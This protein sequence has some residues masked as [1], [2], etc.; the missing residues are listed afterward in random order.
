MRG[1]SA[2]GLRQPTR[3][4]IAAVAVAGTAL[5]VAA[6][7]TVRAPGG[8]QKTVNGLSTT[9]STRTAPADSR[10]GAEAYAHRLLASLRLPPGAQELPWSAKLARGLSPGWP[11][12]L[13]DQID[14]RVLYHVSPSMAEV[15]RYLLAHRPVGLTVNSN[16]YSS[17]YG[18]V[19]S[20]FVGFTPKAPPAGIYS[21]DLDGSVKP[22]RAGGSL[23]RADAIVAGYPPRSAAEY[24]NPSRYIAVTVSHRTNKTIH[25]R[26][27]TSRPELAKLAGLVNSRYGAPDVVTSCPAMIGGVIN[28]YKLV[29]T[30]APGAPKIVVTPST[31]CLQY[32]GVTVGRRVEPSLAGASSLVRVIQRLVRPR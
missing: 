19:T 5:V 11:A 22:A 24:I 30:P 23:L 12:I 10:A 1:P 9:T 3:F 4:V 7:G 26:T 6:C 25:A 31:A 27:F 20:E 8:P 28:V 16:G 14:V 21:A 29:F 32:V 15:Y 17:H 2:P 13:S 18:N